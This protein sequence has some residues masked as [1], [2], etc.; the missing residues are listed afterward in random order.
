MAG[1]SP[2]HEHYLLECPVCGSQFPVCGQ[3]CFVFCPHDQTVL[4]IDWSGT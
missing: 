1:G 2:A 3:P 4:W